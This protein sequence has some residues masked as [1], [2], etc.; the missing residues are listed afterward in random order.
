MSGRETHLWFF[1]FFVSTRQPS[2]KYHVFCFKPTYQ[3]ENLQE[4]ILSCIRNNQRDQKLLYEHF[5]GYC[6]KTVFRYIYHYDKAVDIVNDGFIK[7]FRNLHKFE[8]KPDVNVQMLLMGW[9]RMI[10]VNTAIDHLRQNSFK[11]E[12]GEIPEYIWESHDNSQSSDQPLL[13]KELIKEIRK[14]PP[15]YRAVF[16]MYVIDG[17]THKEISER[18]GISVGTSKSNLS[19]ARVILQGI[20]KK[21]ELLPYA[22]AE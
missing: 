13:Y 11:T 8:C 12:Y 6:L 7:I 15:G 9:M 5:Y 20:I 19:K 17:Y 2:K 14:L 16:N 1:L 10:M 22:T 18:L 21:S 4:I 3:L